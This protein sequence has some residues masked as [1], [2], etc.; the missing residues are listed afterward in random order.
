M[1][2]PLHGLW[3]IVDRDDPLVALLGPQRAAILAAL[4]AP[5]SI[6]AI[7]DVLLAVPSAATHHVT[8]LEAAGL[9][10]RRQRGRH[11][12]VERTARG[13]ELLRLYER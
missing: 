9:V 4:N 7:A 12:L 13:T 1:S 3:R 10:A 2:N 8:A 6:G 5:M 11:V